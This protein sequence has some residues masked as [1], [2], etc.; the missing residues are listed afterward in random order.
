MRRALPSAV[1]VSDRWHLWKNL[2]DKALAEVRSH[3]ACWAT[4]NTPRPAGV[5][6][7]PTRERW[8]QVHDLLGKGVGLL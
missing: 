5:H 8:H 6:E 2:C 7:Q 4:A 3:S 1:Q